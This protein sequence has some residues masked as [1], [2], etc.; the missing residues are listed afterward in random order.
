MA[1]KYYFIHAELHTTSGSD[2]SISVINGIYEID[3]PQNIV[4]FIENH[5][6]VSSYF[7]YVMWEIKLI[8]I[9]LLS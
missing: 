5:F 9:Q 1:L 6:R 2:K 8:N 4:P 3:E 7:S